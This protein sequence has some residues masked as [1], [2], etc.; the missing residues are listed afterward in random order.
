MS[1]DYEVGLLANQEISSF[2]QSGV[3]MGEIDNMVFKNCRNLIQNFHKTNK[4][5]EEDA[6]FMFPKYHHKR[7][8][9]EGL[10]KP[11]LD[12]RWVLRESF[13]SDQRSQFMTL[14]YMSRP[15]SSVPLSKTL[16]PKTHK[17]MDTNKVIVIHSERQNFSGNSS[18]LS[19]QK[20][21]TIEPIFKKI[22]T[23]L[24]QNDD[25]IEVDREDIE[26]VLLAYGLNM[27]CSKS[28]SKVEIFAKLV[29]QEIKN[30]NNAMVW[31]AGLIKLDSVMEFRVELLGKKH[32]EES[33]TKTSY[34]NT[35]NKYDCEEALT[36]RK[37]SRVKFDLWKWPKRKKKENKGMSNLRQTANLMTDW[38]CLVFSRSFV[39]LKEIFEEKREIGM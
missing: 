8:D 21:E 9:I 18:S 7:Q 38:A 39:V 14:P 13:E 16:F 25:D 5:F 31:R 1:N 3:F 12:E 23:S 24:S 35:F 4:K 15:S 32:H 20:V 37:K 34:M 28:T 29:K 26:N 27:D 33:E 30:L 6:R 19:S 36:G 22:N 2:I 10:A 11:L 17:A